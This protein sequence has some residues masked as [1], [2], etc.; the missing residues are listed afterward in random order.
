VGESSSLG[1]A[2]QVTVLVQ[3]WCC[4]HPPHDFQPNQPWL[5]TAVPPVAPCTSTH[6]EAHTPQCKQEAGLGAP[7]VSLERQCQCNTARTVLPT[8][9]V[10]RAF[11]SGHVPRAPRRRQRRWRTE[12]TLL[13]ERNLETQARA[14]LPTGEGCRTRK[15]QRPTTVTGRRPAGHSGS[16]SPVPYLGD[17]V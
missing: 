9:E 15:G 17:V 7:W 16:P 10:C 6:L 2:S 8:A 11:P 4:A 3:T 12:K 14:L 5:L 13:H 1:Q